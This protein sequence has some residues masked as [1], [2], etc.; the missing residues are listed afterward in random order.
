MIK[1]NKYEEVGG[2]E[3]KYRIAFN[4]VDFC[5]KLR[6]AGYYNIYTPHVELY[7]HESVSVG[8]IIDGTRDIKEFK[9]EIDLLN[10]RWRE[11]ILNDPF[12]NKNLS[13]VVA[14]FSIRIPE[15]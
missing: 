3:E 10:S 1:K 2:L 13:L 11:W 12:Y 8:T 9:K 14:D 5:L 15:N 4:D 7:H 6:D